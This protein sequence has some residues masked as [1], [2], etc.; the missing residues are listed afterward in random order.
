ME[1]EAVILIRELKMNADET[2]EVMRIW[3]EATI[4]SHRF[5]PEEYW[6]R[7]YDTIKEKYI[8]VAKTYGYLEENEIKGFISI[9]DEEFIGALF[10]EIDYQGRGIGKQ[11]IDHAK[12]IHDKLILAVYKENEKAVGFYKRVGFIVEHEQL[13][14]ETNRSEYIM[15]F[16]KK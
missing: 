7:S 12:G 11:L 14:E 15:V 1:M 16:N 13:N 5:I 10:V 4:N 2:N 8:P 9:L 6:L 3:K